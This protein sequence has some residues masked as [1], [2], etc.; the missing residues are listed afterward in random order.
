MVYVVSHSLENN[1]VGSSGTLFR[2]LVYFVLFKVAV[3]SLIPFTLFVDFWDVGMMVG[4]EE[5]LG[6][7]DGNM[8]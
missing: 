8:Y 3:C 4:S 1:Y 5:L 2:Y 6:S 7:Q